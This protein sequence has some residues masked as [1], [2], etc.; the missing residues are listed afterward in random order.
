MGFEAI[1]IPALIGAAGAYMSARQA[2]KSQERIAGK[3]EDA[4]RQMQEMLQ[5]P[6]AP[7][8]TAE[9]FA[10]PPPTLVSPLLKGDAKN[11]MESPSTGLA[12]DPGDDELQKM[13]RGS[14]TPMGGMGV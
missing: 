4:Q 8:A 3:Q 14:Q 10:P 6:D 7:L 9:T 2:G 11:V 12:K 13:L 5:P 1:Y